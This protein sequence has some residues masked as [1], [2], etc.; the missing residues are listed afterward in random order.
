MTTLEARE[1]CEG[2]IFV[3]SFYISVHP[4]TTPAYA[5]G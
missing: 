3:N 1:V 4:S 2:V 5:G